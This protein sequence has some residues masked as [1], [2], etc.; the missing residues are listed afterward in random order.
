MTIQRAREI[1]GDIIQDMTN[2]EVAEMIERD[3]GAIRAILTVFEQY[4][5][6]EKRRW[7]T[8]HSEK[9]MRHLHSRVGR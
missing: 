8:G 2:D 7:N 6:N 9:K 5:T 1:F 3:T 4:L